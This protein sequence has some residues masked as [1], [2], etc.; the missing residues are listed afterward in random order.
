MNIPTMPEH[1][2]MMACQREVCAVRAYLRSLADRGFSI[3]SVNEYGETEGD[4]F[5]LTDTELYRFFGVNTAEL[6]R[7]RE[8]ALHYVMSQQG[9]AL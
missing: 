9:M 6:E 1:Q 8:A 7:E 2:K 3:V 4:N 5:V